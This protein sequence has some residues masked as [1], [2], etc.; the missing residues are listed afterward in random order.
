MELTP[1]MEKYVLHWGEMG[2]RWGVNRTVAQVQALLYLSPKVMTA[3]EIAC[4]LAVSRANVSLA[5]RELQ[6]WG[7]VRL[8]HVLGDRRDYFES[9]KDVWEMLQVVMDQ[10]KAREIDPTLT[11]LRECVV[12]ADA[13]TETCEHCREKMK[14]MLDFFE[15]VNTWYGQV[16]RMPKGAVVKFVKLGDQILKFV[17]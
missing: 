10:R 5:L 11:V 13:E 9:M 1:V 12:D 17:G 4:T 15:T 16:R 6:S 3:D 7:L 2:T 8:V 14:E